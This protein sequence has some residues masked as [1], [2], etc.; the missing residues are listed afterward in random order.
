MTKDLKPGLSAKLV[1]FILMKQ[2]S[3]Y[4]GKN[5]EILLAFWTKETHERTIDYKKGAVKPN[6]TTDKKG[7]A[8]PYFPGVEDIYHMA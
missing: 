6:Q 5:E 7:R 3:I 8:G 1:E 2:T 4:W